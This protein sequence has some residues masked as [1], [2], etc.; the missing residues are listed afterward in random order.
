MKRLLIA[1]VGAS[2]VFTAATGAERNTGK[3]TGSG[4]AGRAAIEAC[5][6]LAAIADDADRPSQIPGVEDP[7]VSSNHEKAVGACR[8]AVDVASKT[9]HAAVDVRRVQ[10]ELARSLYLSP[11]G[12]EEAGV[13]YEK[14]AGAGSIKAAFL[15]GKYFD[16]GTE[17]SRLWLNKAAVAGSVEAMIGLCESYVAL[18]KESEYELSRKWCEKVAETG[19]TDV[20][21]WIAT[22]HLSLGKYSTDVN[23]AI[24]WFEKAA[25]IG[26]SSAMMNLGD[27]YDRG[28]GDLKPDMLTARSWYEK[29]LKAGHPTAASSLDALNKRRR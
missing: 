28:D 8:S 19:N 26:D 27:L 1:L 18:E 20:M 12:W 9:P 25:A 2:V 6:R 7:D 5:D 23:L 4:N 29:A 24:K 14:A 21:N 3:S 11:D 10:L 16:L 22:N 13:W 17:K 15:A